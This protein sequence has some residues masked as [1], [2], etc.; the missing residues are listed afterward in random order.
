MEGLGKMATRPLAI[1][2]CIGVDAAVDMPQG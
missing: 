2:I 1:G